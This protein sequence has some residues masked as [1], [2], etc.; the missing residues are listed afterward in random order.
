[1]VARISYFFE[2]IGWVR[3]SMEREDSTLGYRE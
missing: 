1:M 2:M 3:S